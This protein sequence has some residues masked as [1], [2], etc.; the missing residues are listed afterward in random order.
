MSADSCMPAF[1][2]SSDGV[3]LPRTHGCEAASSSTRQAAR[4]NAQQ[5]VQ[6]QAAHPALQHAI[7]ALQ[8]HRLADAERIVRQ[9]LLQHPDDVA[10]L[11]ILGDLAAR[12]GVFDEAERLFRRALDLLPEFP[13]AR[14][15]LARL[16]AQRDALPEAIDQLTALL[17]AD[18]DQPSMRLLRLAWLGQLGRYEQAAA[19]YPHLLNQFPDCH[20]GWTAY[21]HLLGTLGNVSDA[22]T[23]YRRAIALEPAHG[24]AWWG[25]ANLKI[26]KFDPADVAR[27]QELASDNR[28]TD[29]EASL[30]LFALAKG[31][32]DRGDHHAAFLRYQ[33]ANG[34]R[35]QA[36]PPAIDPIRS[37]V[38][39]SIAFFTADR[40]R[41]R[42]PAR[43]AGRRPIFIVGMPRS[44]STLVEQILASHP[45][46]EGTSELPYIP[47]LVHRLLQERRAERNL[48]FPDVLASLSSERLD[49]L[50]RIYLRA[51]SAHCRE[52]TPFFIDKLPD[53]WRYVGFIRMI[54]PE[55]RIIDARRAP[56]ACLWSNFRQWFAR[57]QEYSYDVDELVEQY[58]QYLRLTRHFDA[59][60]PDLLLRIRHEELLASGEQGIRALLEALDLP[61]AEACLRFHENRRPV[62]TASAQQVRRPLDDRS[63]REWQKFRPWIDEFERKVGALE[64][65]D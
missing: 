7:A 16:L 3:D 17:E 50:G 6:R 1:R 47:M 59:V 45:L 56:M 44:G 52:A 49:E 29:S 46:V 33:E 14:L 38:D 34:R 22:I 15:N 58:R 12:A 25:L 31:L 54:L 13:D 30:L 21:G 64:V 28:R 35:H 11:C 57:G 26:L 61:F 53:N 62:R 65:V 63:T 37:E 41:L 55:A 20:E 42:R 8:E 4:L 9:H 27:L 40:L 18:P 36:L 10:A 2:P 39:R 23:A 48:R 32:E 60:A 51:A 5:Q 19:E 43:D 24:E